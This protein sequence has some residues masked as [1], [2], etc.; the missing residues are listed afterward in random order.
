MPTSDS[1]AARLQLPRLLVALITLTALL[2]GS[3]AALGLASAQNAPTFDVRVRAQ[4]HEDGRIEFG[5][6]ADGEVL[7]PSRRFL[8]AEPRIGR[9]YVSTVVE[10]LGVQLQVIAIRQADGDTEFGIRADGETVLRNQIFPAG[11]REHLWLQSS[12][13]KVVSPEDAGDLVIYSGRGESLVGGLIDRF[14]EQTGIDVKVRYGNTAALAIA[15]SEE[16]SRSP[17]DVYYGQDA[18]ALSFLAE[19]AL[20]A[21]LPPDI[22]AMVDRN[23]QDDDGRWI[24]TSG[25]ARVLIISPDRV[26]NPPDSVFD[27][28]DPEWKG[29]I[30]WA[31]TNGSFQAFVTAM[32]Q[33]HG[34]AATEEWLR[35]MI[36]NDVKV[37]PKNTPQVQAVGDG[38]LD[39]GLVNHYYLFRFDDDWPAA[40]HFTDSGNAGALI[41]VAGV[42][43]LEGSSNRANALR[44]IRFL[45]SEEG[46]TYFRDQTNEYPVASGVDANPRL[47]PLDELNPPSLALTSLSDLDGTL[48]LLRKVGALE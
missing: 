39:I 13:A 7:T 17:A 34:D 47:I 10:K 25:R 32:R 27:L 40:N 14:E 6:R 30:G 9:V 36:A 12:V 41:N 22:R 31:P 48:E 29:R 18:G 37:F 5:L 8:P 11:A 28:V 26:P 44:F 4:L 23:F 16:G 24:A 46:Q 1:R 20:A 21:Q 43:M 35:G 19:E 42:A 45:L 15:I 33:I 3:F 2:A 38:E